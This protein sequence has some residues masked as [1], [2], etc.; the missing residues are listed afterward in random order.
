MRLGAS[1]HNISILQAKTIYKGRGSIF[2]EVWQFLIDR[3]SG[4]TVALA[5][6]AGL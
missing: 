5:R 6:R 3:S 4:E 2:P 1:N